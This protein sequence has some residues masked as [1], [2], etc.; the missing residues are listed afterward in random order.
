MSSKRLLK[1]RQS[2][3][4]TNGKL[5]PSTSTPLK[6]TD[7]PLKPTD[8]FLK[9]TDGTL[10]FNAASLKSNAVPLKSTDA[11]LSASKPDTKPQREPILSKQCYNNLAPNLFIFNK[12]V[13]EKIRSSMV[14]MN[15]EVRNGN[16]KYTRGRNSGSRVK[17]AGKSHFNLYQLK[18]QSQPS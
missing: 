18:W 5:D 13:V 7:A 2:T 8:A 14:E 6:F 4:S 3:T 11:L 16:E 12:D 9:S 10:K 15:N 17:L 1:P